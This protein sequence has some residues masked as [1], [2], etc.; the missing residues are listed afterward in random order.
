MILYELD[1]NSSASSQSKICAVDRIH[2]GLKVVFHSRHATPSRS[3]R[4]A[5]LLARIE[6]IRWKILGACV[7]ACWVYSVESVVSSLDYLPYISSQCV[8]LY[9]LN[10]P[11]Q[12]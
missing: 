4:N 10:Y 7:N 12:I 8:R 9:V 11:I 1:F 3:H 2:N 6:H 5:D